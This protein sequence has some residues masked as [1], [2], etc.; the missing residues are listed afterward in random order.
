MGGAPPNNK[1]GLSNPGH[2]F[3][4]PVDNLNYIAQKFLHPAQQ[5]RNPDPDGRF[6]GLKPFEHHHVPEEIKNHF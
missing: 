2:D 1:R 6:G 3:S 5:P 4:D